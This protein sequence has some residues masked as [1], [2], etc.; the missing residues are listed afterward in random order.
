[1]VIKKSD[2]V[3]HPPSGSNYPGKEDANPYVFYPPHELRRLVNIERDQE[4]LAKIKSALKQWE[5][6]YV[7]PGYPWRM[8][9]RLR[10]IAR[11]L[12]KISAV[13]HPSQNI[14]YYQ[15]SE[16]SE[17][18]E[19]ILHGPGLSSPGLSG[20]YDNYDMDKFDYARQGE[21]P[22]RDIDT[23]GGKNFLAPSEPPIGDTVKTKGEGPNPDIEYPFP[24]TGG[25]IGGM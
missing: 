9:A 2:S 10:R 23:G 7:Y 19:G 4:K 14:P 22:K 12:M 16:V 3:F 18:Y 13:P 20:P 24:P 5:R 1:M 25:D 11:K 21:R 15:D 6:I 8:A 17:G